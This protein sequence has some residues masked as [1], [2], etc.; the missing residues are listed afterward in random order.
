MFKFL[1]L[2]YL[3]DTENNSEGQG[4]REGERHGHTCRPASLMTLSACRRGQALE[5][6]SL[7]TVKSALLSC[8]FHAYTVT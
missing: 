3:L 2:Y 8:S 4:D 5:P 6:E 7:H 1:N